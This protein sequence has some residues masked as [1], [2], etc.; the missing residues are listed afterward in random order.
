MHDHSCT[1]K[2]FKVIRG[3][4][5][6]PMEEGPVDAMVA[7]AGLLIAAVPKHLQRHQL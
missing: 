3:T 5:K 1:E 2:P 4:S 6:V 7:S